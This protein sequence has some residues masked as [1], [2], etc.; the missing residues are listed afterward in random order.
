M[1][2]VPIVVILGV[3]LTIAAI[4]P[5]I[6]PYAESLIVIE[7][8]AIVGGVYLLALAFGYQSYPLAYSLL[9]AFVVFVF[10]YPFYFWPIQEKRH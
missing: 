10:G 7:C 1:D 5:W 4:W 9:G 6:G 8:I 3:A 2:A